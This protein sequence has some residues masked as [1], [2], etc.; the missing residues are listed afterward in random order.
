MYTPPDFSPCAAPDGTVTILFS[1]I[2]GCTAMT[3]RLGDQVMQ[4]VLRDHNALIRRE[5]ASHDG[6][7]VKSMG[8]GF[9]LAFSSA[10][11]A[12][13]CAAAIQHAFRDYNGNHPQEPVRVRMGLH[14]GEAI[15]EDGDFFGR[16]VILASRITDQAHGGQILISSLLKD[17][18]ESAGDWAFRDEREIALKGLPGLH[19]MFLVDW[20]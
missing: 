19:R 20:R 5:V 8:D 3:H 18:V 1:D 10:R 14:T 15:R 16:N 6:F 12:L 9:M 4:G 11:P 2:E 7:E 17:L 13:E